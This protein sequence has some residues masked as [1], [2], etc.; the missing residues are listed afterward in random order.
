[1]STDRYVPLRN[2]GCPAE[3]QYVLLLVR[4]G[5]GSVLDV[6]NVQ[7]IRRTVQKIYI[8]DFENTLPPP[9]FLGFRLHSRLQQIPDHS[10]QVLN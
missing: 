1:M 6:K 8:N 3:V 5:N 2:G 9:Y 4:G 7:S 10:T